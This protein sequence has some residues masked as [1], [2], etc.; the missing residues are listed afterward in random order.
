MFNCISAGLIINEA[1]PWPAYEASEKPGT[2]AYYAP[3]EG[4]KDQSEFVSTG[5]PEKT[6]R[7]NVLVDLVGEDVLESLFKPV[8]CSW[9]VHCSSE[10]GKAQCS[11]CWQSGRKL[12]WISGS[13][14]C[15]IERFNQTWHQVEPGSPNR[16]MTRTRGGAS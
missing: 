12:N 10:G 5:T 9:S 1:E 16:P 14:K 13:H 3:I 11:T 7:T 2:M 15:A 4:N 8:R 6:G